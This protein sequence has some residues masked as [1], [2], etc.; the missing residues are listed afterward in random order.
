MST[1]PDKLSPS[2]CWCR[3]CTDCL[4]SLRPHRGQ[5]FYP[6]LAH[7]GAL[8][9]GEESLV[10]GDFLLD[11]VP[12][13]LHERGLIGSSIVGPHFFEDHL[14]RLL[15]TVIAFGKKAFL[16]AQIVLSGRPAHEYPEL[17]CL[18]LLAAQRLRRCGD[19]RIRC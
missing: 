14:G 9:L 16:D 18:R 4:S 12:P 7:P 10:S 2:R 11:Q 5:Y 15:G 17:P 1:I 6:L 13:V 3:R 8:F 19:I